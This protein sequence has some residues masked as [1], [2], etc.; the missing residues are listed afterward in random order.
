M[1]RLGSHFLAYG[2]TDQSTLKAAT[3]SYDGIVV[4][5]TIATFQADGTRG[6]VLTL[7][8]A[9]RKPYVV[10]PRTPLFQNAID[11]P[12]RSHTTLAKVLGLEEV[13]AA[14]SFVPLAHWS[15]ANIAL[16]AER[17]LTF[18]T[19][20]ASVTPKA[21]DKYARRLNRRLVQQDA[22]GPSWV[23]AP[24]LTISGLSSRE[25]AVSDELWSAT[26]DLAAERA[27][28]QQLV[29]V[30][31]VDEPRDLAAYAVES[32]E[33]EVMVWVSNLDENSLGSADRLREYAFAVRSMAEEGIRPFA[34][35]GGFFSVLLGSVGLVGASHGVGFSEH[36]NHV[37]L[38]SSGAAPARFYVERIHRYVSV[39]LA[40]ELWRRDPTTVASYYPGFTGRDPQDYEYHDLMLHSVLARAHEIQVSRGL[41]A[42]V[43]VDQLDSDLSSYLRQLSSMRLTEGLRRRMEQV[44]APLAMWSNAL[45]PVA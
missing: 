5:G 1:F 6:F 31:A 36:R 23:L 20:F 4:P 45:G 13:F 33:R 14:N 30:I 10:D 43:L 27:I 42:R 7:S 21:F 40:S 19:Q 25:R 8:A 12:K 32:G 28:A 37:E 2:S 44:L 9:E 15:G 24:Y 35:Y 16:T 29:R 18:N 11:S 38:K 22:E 41:S 34:L 17:W 26:V 39:D 3:S